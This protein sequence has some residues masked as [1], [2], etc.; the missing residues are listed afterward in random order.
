[1]RKKQRN[2][3]LSRLQQDSWERRFAT[4]R[5]CFRRVESVFPRGRGRFSLSFPFVT[6]SG[7]KGLKAEILRIAQ[8][9]RLM[10]FWRGLSVFQHSQFPP[11][12]GFRISDFGFFAREGAL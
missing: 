1:M 7:A 12:F 10:V 2:P 3:N 8:N 9:D 4:I 6:L 11:S 5:R